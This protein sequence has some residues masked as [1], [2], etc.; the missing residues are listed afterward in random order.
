MCL[1]I[2]PKRMR[3]LGYYANGNVALRGWK[4]F[5]RACHDPHRLRTFYQHTPIQGFDKRIQASG[6]FEMDALIHSRLLQ[7]N[8]LPN[9][10]SGV[11]HL[12]TSRKQAKIL[13]ATELDYAN[14]FITRKG[15]GPRWR[16]VIYPVYFHLC[17]LLYLGLHGDAAVSAYY[18]SLRAFRKDHPGTS[19]CR[20]TGL[21]TFTAQLDDLAARLHL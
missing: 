3:A 17:D 1:T 6:R 16:G 15:K 19:T 2:D 21:F 9:I 7:A 11:L 10:T 14:G 4:V 18:L 13:L 12:Y 20:P 8:C 5:L